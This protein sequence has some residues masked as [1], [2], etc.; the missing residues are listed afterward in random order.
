M[1][2]LTR[3]GVLAAA[4]LTPIAAGAVE[5]PAGSPLRKAVLDAMRPYTERDLGPPIQYVIK[6]MN[7]EGNIAFVSATPQRLNGQKIDWRRFPFHRTMQAGGMSDEV[8][9]LLRFENGVWRVKEYEF[10]FTD[11]VWMD[12]PTRYRFP[13]RLITDAFH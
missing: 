1:N 3:R 10:G 6:G 8:A 5:P 7:V 11:V 13:E 9:A 4:L 12:W 2:R